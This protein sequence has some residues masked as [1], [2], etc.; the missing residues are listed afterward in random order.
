MIFDE[1][2]LLIYW[3]SSEIRPRKNILVFLVIFLKKEGRYAGKTINN[4]F[5]TG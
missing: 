1:L 5:L 3:K 4:F 2:I